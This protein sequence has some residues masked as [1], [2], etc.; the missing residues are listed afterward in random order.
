MTKVRSATVTSQG[1]SAQPEGLMTSADATDG[2]GKSPTHLETFVA[3]VAHEVR[4]PLAIAKGALAMLAEIDAGGDAEPGTREDLLAMVQ[5]NLDLAMLLM[6]RMALARDIENGTVTL[7]REALDLVN[8]VKESVDDLRWAALRDH[9]VE[10]DAIDTLVVNA[11]PTAVRE[12]VFNL[13]ANAAKYSA[14]TAPIN[15]AVDRHNDSAR[16]VVRNHGSGVTPGDSEHI[17]DKFFQADTNSP[18]VGLGLFVSRGLARAHGGNISVH[19]A[20]D[21]G[22]EFVLELPVA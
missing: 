16:M 19:P 13:L 1:P 6:D 3:L 4:T 15:V 20:K 22:S 14:P 7:T 10:I 9:P 21:H 18:G 2:G 12:I 17:F 11:D 5:R 8:L